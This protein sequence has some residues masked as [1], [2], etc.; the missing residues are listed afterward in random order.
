MRRIIFI[1]NKTAFITFAILSIIIILVSKIQSRQSKIKSQDFE[2]LQS[3]II[4]KLDSVHKIQNAIIVY[5]SVNQLSEK[6][7][8]LDTIFNDL[9]TT[10]SKSKDS[11][12]LIA[13]L[14]SL[15]MAIVTIENQ[16]TKYIESFDSLSPIYPI[17]FRDSVQIQSSTL[18]NDLLETMQCNI[19][20]FDS[21]L[22][23][24]DI[25][26]YLLTSFII[27]LF[28]IRWLLQWIYRNKNGT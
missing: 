4:N 27:I 17:S 24:S 25:L 8:I 6:I 2:T 16:R 11:L 15:N 10:P 26:K 3:K 18:N 7:K 9:K 21:Q 19:D 22:L 20:R 12:S 1:S 23:L 13:Q 28:P 14:D 5:D